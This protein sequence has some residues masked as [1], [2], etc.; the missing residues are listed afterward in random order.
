MI[1]SASRRTDIP[2]FYANWFIGR[3][4]AGFCEVSNPF[5]P[6]QVTRVSLLPED[7]EVIV[8]WTRNPRPMMR[9]LP[10]L[11]ARGYRYYFLFTV[12]DYPRLLETATPSLPTAISVFKRLVDTMG[13]ER[14]VWR[15]DPIIFSNL[16][17][18]AFHEATFARVASALRG[19]TTRCVISFLTPYRKVLRRLSR[20]ETRGFRLEEI[21]AEARDQLLRRLADCARQNAMELMGCAT[22]GEFHLLGIQDGKCIDDDLIRRA[23]GM[24]VPGRK[25]PCQRESCRCIVSR[26]IGAYDTCPFGCQYCYATSSFELAKSR[27]RRHHPDAVALL[28]P[29]NSTSSQTR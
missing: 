26:D 24:S 13:P 20:L 15:Y 11:T 1:I 28:L 6:R 3:I 17:G 25:D 22:G 18:P 21:K 5:N 4:R 19:Q 29:E 23:F 27:Y 12:V 2:A 7:V 9:F 14:V 8:F 10:E 16:T